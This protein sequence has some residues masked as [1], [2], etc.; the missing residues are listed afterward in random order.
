MVKFK[1]YESG[2]SNQTHPFHTNIVSFDTAKQEFAFIK[3]LLEMRIFYYY[4]N[5]CKSQNAFLVLF[6]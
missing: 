6:I 1:N 2:F 3:F 5:E 4:H